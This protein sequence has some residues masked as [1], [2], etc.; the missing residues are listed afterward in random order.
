MNSRERVLTALNRQVPD[1]V[2][3]DFGSFPGA[4]SINVEAYRNFLK[5]LGL[6][7]EVRIANILMFTAEV[8]EDI[9]DRFHI[10]TISIKPAISQKQFGIPAEFIDRPWGVRWQKSSDCT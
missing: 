6:H 7:R 8:D 9:L 2:P 10:D 4:T 5:F 3:I 1:R